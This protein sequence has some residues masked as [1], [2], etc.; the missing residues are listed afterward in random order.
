MLV[1][2]LRLTDLSPRMAAWSLALP[3]GIA[4]RLGMEERAGGR[5]SDL[6]TALLGAGSFFLPCGFTQTVQVYALSTASS[7]RAAM[8]MGAFALGTA[9]GL[10]GIGGL[11]AAARGRAGQVFTR[12]A[13]VAVIGLAFVNVNG[14]VANLGWKTVGGVASAE[15]LTPNVTIVDGVQVV[16]T[17]QTAAG[18]TPSKT[19]VYRGMPVRWEVTSTAPFSCSASLYA[20]GIADGRSLKS[21]L[22]TFDFTPARDGVIRYQ[23]SMGMYGGTIKVVDPPPPTTA[24]TGGTAV[25]PNSTP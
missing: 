10:L 12:F 6:R 20:P 25:T 18:Y 19:V 3:S 11:A 7:P 23:C 22:N 15:T 13:G 2:G 14:A 24:V 21:G 5:Y 17:K 4:T 8:I 9:P 1:L 16:H